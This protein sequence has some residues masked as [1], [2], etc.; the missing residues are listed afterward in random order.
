MITRL[1]FTETGALDPSSTNIRDL[2]TVTL[3]W[4]TDRWL[5]QVGLP[6]LQLEKLEWSPHR[7]ILH[8]Q[9]SDRT[10]DE[11]STTFTLQARNSNQTV[12]KVR[13]IVTL[14]TAAAAASLPTPDGWSLAKRIRLV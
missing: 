1:V 4:A 2:G 10:T 13:P 7:E 11:H 6:D 9:L 3:T 8:T 12:R 5:L 14:K